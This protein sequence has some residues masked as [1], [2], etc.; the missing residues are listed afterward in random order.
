MG[1]AS[2]RLEGAE[3]QKALAETL[4]PQRPIGQISTTFHPL[5]SGQSE[6]PTPEA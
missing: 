6:S 2:G 3:D 1:A 4:R 5:Y